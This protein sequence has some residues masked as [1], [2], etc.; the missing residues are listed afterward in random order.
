M[1]VSFQEIELKVRFTSH[2]QLLIWKQGIMEA[3]GKSQPNQLS[4]AK[5]PTRPR[6]DTLVLK[7]PTDKSLTQKPD[8]VSNS[9]P[10]TR[11]QGDEDLDLSI[12]L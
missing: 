4:I 7:M 5:S 8:K 12:D 1:L 9:G 2:E 11:N 10:K 3:L 6:T